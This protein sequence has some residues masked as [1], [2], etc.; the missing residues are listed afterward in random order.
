MVADA[1]GAATIPGSHATVDAF[2]D[3]IF[4]FG[5]G[6]DP[7]LYSF[8]FSPGN[9]QFTR[10]R[11][12]FLKADTLALLIPG[13]PAPAGIAAEKPVPVRAGVI[14]APSATGYW[15]RRAFFSGSM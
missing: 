11:R 9:W 6:V 15:A 14:P 4:S 8:E 2:V 5:P 10:C 12:G 13:S 1:F 7:T 3:P